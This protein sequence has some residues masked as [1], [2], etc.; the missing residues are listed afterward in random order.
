MN[1]IDI[2]AEKWSY[3]VGTIDQKNPK[4]IAVLSQILMDMKI[5]F[6]NVQEV[7]SVLSEYDGK[8]FKNGKPK[9]KSNEE[10]DEKSDE[11]PKEEPIKKDLSD[12]PHTGDVAHDL[13]VDTDKEKKDD[14]ESSD[15]DGE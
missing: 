12:E 1:I 4:H 7:I 3:E 13:K 5:P 15:E 8:P 6:E 9:E 11:K 14:D 2:I 10:P